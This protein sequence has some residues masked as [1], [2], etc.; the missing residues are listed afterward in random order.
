MTDG[1]IHSKGE[2]LLTPGTNQFRYQHFA[3]YEEGESGQVMIE[4]YDQ[5]SIVAIVHTANDDNVGMGG[6]GVWH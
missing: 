1:K 2:E 3:P 4:L 6:T 5:D